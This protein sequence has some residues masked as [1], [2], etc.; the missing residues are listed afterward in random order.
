MGRRN[1]R[2]RCRPPTGRCHRHGVTGYRTQ[3]RSMLRMALPLGTELKPLVDYLNKQPSM[4]MP[5]SRFVTACPMLDVDAHELYRS[6]AGTADPSPCQRRGGDPLRDAPPKLDEPVS[7][8]L[9][10]GDM[11]FVASDGFA[12]AARADS[13]SKTIESS[14]F[15]ELAA[16]SRPGDHR[17][18]P[19]GGCSQATYR[20]MIE[21]GPDPSRVLRRSLPPM[22]IGV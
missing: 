10:P 12:E 17:V 19:R 15:Y 3:V 9:E 5:P 1:D 8:H 20:R 22:P 6:P 13:M 18:H 2:F 4:D 21:R 7:F 16:A 11:F 14:I